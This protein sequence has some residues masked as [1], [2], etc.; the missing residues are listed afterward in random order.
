MNKIKSYLQHLARSW[1][2][3]GY[4]IING[5]LPQIFVDKAQVSLEQSKTRKRLL[6]FLGVAK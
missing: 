4:L 3:A 5:V 1:K 2:I 6:E